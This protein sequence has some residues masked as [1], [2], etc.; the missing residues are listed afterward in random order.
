MS[1]ATHILP[2][3]GLLPVS[4]GILLTCP[5][6]LH[7]ATLWPSQSWCL[8]WNMCPSFDSSA[9]PQKGSRNTIWPRGLLHVL[10][11]LCCV[12]W[13]AMSQHILQNDIELEDQRWRV[14]TLSTPLRFRHLAWLYPFQLFLYDAF[15]QITEMYFVNPLKCWCK[16]VS[17]KYSVMKQLRKF[18]LQLFD[19]IWKWYIFSVRVELYGY[20]Y[21]TILTF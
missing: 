17:Y 7:L 10:V 14:W 12:L 8:P 19:E 5:C 1:K 2:I 4:I 16:Q 15:I 11:R 6:Q 21:K 9:E 3:W 20:I 13:S 18:V